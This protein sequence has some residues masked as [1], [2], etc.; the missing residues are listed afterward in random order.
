MKMLVS[1]LIRMYQTLVS[2]FLGPACRFQP[3]CSEYCRLAVEKKGGWRGLFLGLK[4]ILK[5]HPFHSGG[6]DPIKDS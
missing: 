4:R 6:Y 5:C 2:P 3:N 1:L